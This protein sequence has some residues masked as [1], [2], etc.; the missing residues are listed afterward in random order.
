MAPTGAARGPSRPR[1]SSGSSISTPSAASRS[2]SQA[3]ISSRCS[4]GVC[5]TSPASSAAA[6]SASSSGPIQRP[7]CSQ[8]SCR[9]ATNASRWSPRHRR[10]AHA[11]PCDAVRALLLEDLL[12]ALRPSAPATEST[13]DGDERRQHAVDEQVGGDERVPVG[14]LV[15]EQREPAV[16]AEAVVVGVDAELLEDGV[17]RARVA[18]LVLRHR[19]GGDGGLERRAR[20]RPTPRSGGRAPPCCRPA[21]P[22]SVF[23]A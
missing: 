13:Q 7:A 22:R 14:Q 21:R 3:R 17:G 2:V 6:Y 23:M 5:V 18:E 9:R 8:V 19:G 15:V 1:S 16:A 10:S 4:A 12:R 20:T 11:S